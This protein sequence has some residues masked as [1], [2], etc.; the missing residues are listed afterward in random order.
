MTTNTATATANP[1]TA[2]FWAGYEDGYRYGRCGGRDFGVNDGA[3]V[4]GIG[5]GQEDR[6]KGVRPAGPM[7]EWW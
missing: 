3:Y 6:R 1:V 5:E 2:A 4:R 7:G